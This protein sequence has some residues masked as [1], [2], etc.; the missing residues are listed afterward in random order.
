MILN[1]A[2]T[3]PSLS[4]RRFIPPKSIVINSS[5]VSLLPVKGL[6]STISYHT[7]YVTFPQNKMKRW[8]SHPNAIRLAKMIVQ[9]TKSPRSPRIIAN[10]DELNPDLGQME[11]SQVQPARCRDNC[12]LRVVHS[13]AVGDDNEIERLDS[14]RSKVCAARF[15]LG[16]FE[17]GN[18]SIKYM[19]QAP[20]CR[21][22]R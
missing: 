11:A 13:L 20:S 15:L 3:F 8:K 1:T 18:V 22:A 21:S 14:T 5:G 17:L 19:L 10:L 7:I 16:C 4:T 12:V 6:V 9:I 2:Q